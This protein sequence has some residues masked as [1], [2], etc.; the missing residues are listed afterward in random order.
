MSLSLFFIS[1][2]KFFIGIFFLETTFV[3]PFA[4]YALYAACQLH[5]SKCK[6]DLVFAHCRPTLAA[7]VN[8]ALRWAN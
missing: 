2:S 8:L 4:F 1:S 7:N 3:V 5:F 6:S